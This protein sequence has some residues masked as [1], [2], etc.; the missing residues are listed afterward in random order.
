M[1]LPRRWTIVV[2]IVLL[3]AVFLVG[4]VVAISWA[5]RRRVR[6]ASLV[7]ALG[8]ASGFVLLR[9]QYDLEDS[10]FLWALLVFCV[11]AAAISTA[12]CLALRQDVRSSGRYALLAAAVVPLLFGA[13]LAA[14]YSLCLVT[15]CDHS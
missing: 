12:A 1:S 10:A 9:D 15:H 3:D 5:R 8:A 2:E 13:S 4:A 14:R 7:A 6:F 11:V